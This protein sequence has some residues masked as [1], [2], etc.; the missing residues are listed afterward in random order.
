MDYDLYLGVVSGS[1]N[2]T[3]LSGPVDVNGITNLSRL[4]GKLRQDLES[5]GS[6]VVSLGLQQVSWQ[7]LG[8]VTVVEGQSSREGWGWDTGLNSKSESLSPSGLCLGNS[9]VEEWVEQQVLQVWVLSVSRGDLTQENRSDDTSSSPHESNGWEIELPA[10][11]LGSFSD[12]HESLSIGDDL[13]GVKSLF[14]VVDESLLVSKLRSLGWAG[15]QG[16]GSSS[17]LLQSRKTSS[18]HGLTNQG[19]WHTQVEGVD[20]GPLTGT[21]LA[22]RVQNLLHQWGSVVVVESENVSG[23]LDQERVQNS[24]VPLGKD[25]GDLLVGEATNTLHEVVGLANQLHVTVLD[26]VVDHLDV[27]AG[28][29]I[30]NP[31]T[32]WLAVRLGSNGLENVLDVWPCLDSTTWHQRRTVTGTFL[33]TRHT[34]S[35][36]QN[37][38]LLE[39]GKTSVGVWEVRVTTIDDNVTLLHVR[40][41]LVDE[42][43]DRVSGL[44]KQDNSSRSLKLLA[45]LLDGVGTKNGLALGLVGQEVIHLLNSSVVGNNSKAVVCGIEN[46]ILAHHGQSDQS[47]ITP[48]MLEQHDDCT[49]FG[50]LIFNSY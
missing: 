25:V 32:A 40:Q 34:G 16:A 31:V 1:R 27:V 38:L 29:G 10:V 3:T 45:Q 14:Q 35:N 20:G 37:A 12:Q 6:E 41:K 43:V 28:S 13:G 36:E 17:L 18:E 33:T 5:V 21:L 8:S 23:D 50:S 48:F 9:L 24:L 19:D 46:Q 39:I 2:I 15:K 7:L 30:S 49:Y 4:G 44:H 22:S 11:L 42:T 26:T 47:N